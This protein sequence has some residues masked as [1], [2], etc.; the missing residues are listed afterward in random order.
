[1]SN[2]STA[3]RELDSGRRDEQQLDLV[4]TALAN[5]TRRDLLSRLGRAPAKITDLA[6]PYDMSLPA[7][8]KHLRVLERAGLV[9]R[10]VDGRV[11]QCS[12]DTAPLKEAER[13]LAYYREYWDQTLDSLARHV[14]KDYAGSEQ[15]R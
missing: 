12:L 9:V 1:M 2:S 7:V 11:H 4:F 8:S 13:W 6:K 3:T 15:Q 10:E 5:Q 14:A